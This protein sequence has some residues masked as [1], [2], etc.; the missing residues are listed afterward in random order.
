MALQ[1]NEG[2]I[3]FPATT[4]RRQRVS[5]SV[6]IPGTINSYQVVLKGY[7][8]RYDNGDHHILELEIDLD[9]TRSG[10]TIT[11]TGDFVLRDSSGNF[12]DPY[13]GWINYV[14]VADVN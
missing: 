4:G 1:F 10:N 8:V 12:D 11:V 13:E 9:S 14:V 7:N 6:N 3:N 2:W 5:R